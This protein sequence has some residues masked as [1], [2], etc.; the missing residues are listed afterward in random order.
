MDCPWLSI[1]QWVNDLVP[2]CLNL[3]RFRGYLHG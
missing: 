2:E 3:E 1:G